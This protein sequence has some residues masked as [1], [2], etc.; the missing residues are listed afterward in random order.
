[1]LWKS[2]N[3]PLARASH[4]AIRFAECLSFTEFLNE[5]FQPI[6]SDTLRQKV[7]Q[8]LNQYPITFSTVPGSTCQALMHRVRLL[9]LAA[10]T[11]WAGPL[12]ATM[13]EANPWAY[14]QW[15][16][17]DTTKFA[18]CPNETSTKL[19]TPKKNPVSAPSMD[20][21]RRK[22]RGTRLACII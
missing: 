3:T 20:Q 21:S 18:R 9:W 2:A 16:R 7:A 15:K 6:S 4:S 14:L 19:C 12:D 10:K 22:P 1:M 13:F 8:Y 11:K 17:C 5:D